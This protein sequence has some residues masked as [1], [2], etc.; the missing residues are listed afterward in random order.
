MGSNETNTVNLVHEEELEIGEASASINENV[1]I[2]VN[3]PKDSMRVDR[4]APITL[5]LTESLVDAIFFS[6]S[7]FST[8]D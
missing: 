1:P 6:P 2:E 7:S 8:D 3:N 5:L 4:K